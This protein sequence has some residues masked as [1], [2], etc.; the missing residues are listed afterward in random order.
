MQPAGKPTIRPYQA[1][2]TPLPDN[3]SSNAVVSPGLSSMASNSSAATKA[4]ATKIGLEKHPGQPAAPAKPVIRT[5]AQ[6]DAA[7]AFMGNMA[8]LLD[9]M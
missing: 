7:K 9:S 8:S 2:T 3:A 5:E 1:S 4:L 6:R